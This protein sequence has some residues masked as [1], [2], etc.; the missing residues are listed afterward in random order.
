MTYRAGIHLTANESAI[1][2]CR[3]AR[4]TINFMSFRDVILVSFTYSKYMCEHDTD[5]LQVD[6]RH[7]RAQEKTQKMVFR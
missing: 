1:I 5:L 4:I 2:S 7:T 6:Q 3:L